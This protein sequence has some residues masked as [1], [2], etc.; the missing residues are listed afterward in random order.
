MRFE[1]RDG[2]VHQ[3]EKYYEKRAHFVHHQV[4]RSNLVYNHFDG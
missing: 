1:L 3:K 2:K 4:A